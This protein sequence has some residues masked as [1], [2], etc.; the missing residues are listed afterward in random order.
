MHH[1]YQSVMNSERALT[2]SVRGTSAPHSHRVDP[3]QM[4]AILGNRASRF[5]TFWNSSTPSKALDAQI[6][7]S[8]LEATLARRLFKSPKLSL[9]TKQGYPSLSSADRRRC[10]ATDKLL[11]L[12]GHFF[13]LGPFGGAADTGGGSTIICFG[14]VTRVDLIGPTPTPM[15]T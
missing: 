14:R 7:P 11:L 10:S 13:F 12:I 2:M 6:E 8:S 5:V 15:E 3:F 9:M 1:L 4:I